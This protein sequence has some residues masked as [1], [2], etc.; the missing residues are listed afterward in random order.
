MTIPFER[1]RAVLQTRELLKRLMD[2]KDTPRVPRWLRGQAKSLL[3]HYPGHQ[4]LR[5][6]SSHKPCD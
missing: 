4:A 2:P 6:S 3:R 1:T 5:S